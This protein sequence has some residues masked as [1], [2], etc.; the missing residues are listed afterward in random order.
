MRRPLVQTSPPQAHLHKPLVT[1]PPPS[2]RVSPP[3]ARKKAPLIIGGILVYVFS[4]Y[5]VLNYVSLSRQDPA[6]AQDT[7]TSARYDDTASTFD[8]DV[9]FAETTSGIMTSRKKLVGKAYGHVLETSVGTG[10]NAPYYNLKKC[11]S[12]T[13]VDQSAPMV[14]I[15]RDKFYALRPNYRAAA[16]YTQSARSPL[17]SG[18]GTGTTTTTSGPGEGYYDTIVQTMGLC[19]TPEPAALLAHLGTL[20]KPDTGRILLLEHGRSHYRWVNWVLDRAASAHAVRHGCWWNRDIGQIV[21]D[22]GLVIEHVERRHLG[23]FWW[24]EL[25]PRKSSDDEAVAVG[26]KKSTD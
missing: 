5:V 16:F 6:V 21:A 1:N 24:L 11:A 22:S 20:A 8:V 14:R 23:T 18:T 15:A 7:D 12:L 10:R 9:S 13:F 3:P 4:T 2:L 26:Q 19:S 25:K 17:P